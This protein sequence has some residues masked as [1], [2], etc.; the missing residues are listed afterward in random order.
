MEYEE[1]DQSSKKISELPSL[2]VLPDD[3]LF[4]VEHVSGQTSAS[5]KLPYKDFRAAIMPQ[6][7]ASLKLGT[8]A[9]Q[10]ENAYALAAHGHDFTDFWFFPSYGPN[11]NNKQYK[12]A[13]SCNVYGQFDIVKYGP[14]LARTLSSISV[15][16]PKMDA[17]VDVDPPYNPTTI[18]DLQMLAVNCT[19]EHYLTAYRGYALKTY[20][21]GTKNVDIFAPS[22]DGYI[23]PNGTTFTCKDTEF[24]DACKAYSGSQSAQKFTVPCL[25]TFFSGFDSSAFVPG[26]AINNMPLHYIEHQSAMLKHTH[27][28]DATITSQEIT[29]QNVQFKKFTSFYNAPTGYGKDRRFLHGGDGTSEKMENYKVQVRINDNGLK[30][31]GKVVSMPKVSSAGSDKESYPKHTLIPI[32]LY[33]GSRT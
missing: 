14:G 33:I 8:M 6:L 20:P 17:D 23:I 26:V 11:S 32:L 27:S 29:L 15:C 22:F 31:N 12:S 9:Q 4:I 10:D 21:D 7:S 2:S 16:S 28:L 24:K 25:S 13:V 30:M 19:F 5:Y 1:I 18:G 3:A